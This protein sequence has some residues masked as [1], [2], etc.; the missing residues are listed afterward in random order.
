MAQIYVEL[1]SVN[2]RRTVRG[3]LQLLS[4]WTHAVKVCRDICIWCVCVRARALAHVGRFYMSQGLRNIFREFY[5]VQ[6]WRKI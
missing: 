1:L 3:Y 6:E 2:Y 4:H 5:L